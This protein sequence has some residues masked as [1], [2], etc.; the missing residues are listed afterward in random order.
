MRKYYKN[1]YCK[2]LFFILVFLVF[3]IILIKNTIVRDILSLFFISFVIYYV[4]KPIHTFL[5]QKGINEKFSALLLVVTL[6]MII[7]VFIIS[8]I[9][10]IIKEGYNI[11]SSVGYIQKYIDYIYNK[12][13]LLNNNKILGGIL[14]KVNGEI[15]NYTVSIGENILNKFV[16]LG[17]NILDYAVIPIIV[18]YF[19]AAGDKI[20][21]KFFIIFPVKIRGMV[22]NVLEDID[23]ILARYIISQIILCLIITI[24]TFLVLIGLGIKL[25][26]LLSLING[27]FNIIPYFGPVIGS[28]PAILI[29]FT[30]SPKTALWALIL[31]YFIQQIEGDILSPKITGD[32]VDM[33]PLTVILLLLIGGKIYGFAG[34]VLAI[35]IGVIMKII[36]EDLNYYLF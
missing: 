11:T 32:S 10:A 30:K 19:L 7:G 6:I 20:I 21:Q 4:L 31:L 2:L 1:L 26:I 8:I 3:F 29:A 27:F 33:H 28:L 17:E 24:L 23:K 16:G 13:N 15:E 9:P 34:M 25:P 22:K 5:K 12:I 14:N 18:Y 36:Y 35:P